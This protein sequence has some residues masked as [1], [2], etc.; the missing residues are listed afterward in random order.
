MYGCRTSDAVSDGKTVRD[1]RN[2]YDVRSG[3]ALAREV[4]GPRREAREDLHKVR[5][6]AELE[7]KNVEVHS[8]SEMR[9]GRTKSSPIWSSSGTA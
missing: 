9:L 4:Q 6:E 7:G 2:T 5:K 8:K 1:T 3:V